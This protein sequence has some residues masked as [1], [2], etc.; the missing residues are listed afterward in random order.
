MPIANLES[1]IL[2]HK[3]IFCCCTVE[4]C[5]KTALE[6]D[7][8]PPLSLMISS[9]L[10]SLCK[11]HYTIWTHDMKLLKRFFSLRRLIHESVGLIVAFG[12]WTYNIWTATHFLSQQQVKADWDFVTPRFI[13]WDLHPVPRAINSLWLMVVPINS[14]NLFSWAHGKYRYC[15]YNLHLHCGLFSFISFI[16]IS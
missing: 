9:P 4:V 10:S 2:K 16:D 14:S 13:S 8:F 15:V 1:T 7:K 3:A 11:K 5:L 12:K 6:Y